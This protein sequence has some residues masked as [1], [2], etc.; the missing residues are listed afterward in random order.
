MQHLKFKL[1]ARLT[2]IVMLAAPALATADHTPNCH[3]G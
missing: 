3:R 2:P 1:I